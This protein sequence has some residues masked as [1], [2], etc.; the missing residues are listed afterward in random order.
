MIIHCNHANEID[1]SVITAIRKL[2]QA[3]VMVY[4]QA[5]LLRGVN[6]NV[7][8][9]VD[10]QKRLFALNVQPYYLHLLDRVQG[11]AHFDIPE[12]EAHE[13]YRQLQAKLSGYLVPK[14]VREEAGA[15][16]KSIISIELEKK[17]VRVLS[18]PKREKE[19]RSS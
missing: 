7:D 16:A 13:L 5:V 3:G 18:F 17:P 15:P 6:D 1:A 12:A 9:L 4:N 11:A 8:V 10:L 19:V 2:Q 14:L